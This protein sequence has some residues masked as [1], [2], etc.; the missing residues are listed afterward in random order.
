LLKLGFE[1]S[2]I[3]ND[4]GSLYIILII[5]YHKN[6]KNYTD[7]EDKIEKKFSQKDKKKAKKMKVS[8]KQVFGLKKIITEKGK[9]PAT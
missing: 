4:V 6:M 9:P 7:I 5:L 2:G 3:L 1:D 8:G